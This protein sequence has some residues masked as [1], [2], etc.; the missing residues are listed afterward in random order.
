MLAYFLI[1]GYV[2]QWLVRQYERR[3]RV[4]GDNCSRR[5]SGSSCKNLTSIAQRNVVA[6]LTAMRQ[7]GGWIEAGK[8]A[9]VVDTMG[10]VEIPAG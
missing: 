6:V 1:T 8:G 3:V 5:R 2:L 10:L 4:P 9:E 7:I